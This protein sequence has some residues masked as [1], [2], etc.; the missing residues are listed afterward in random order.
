MGIDFNDLANKL[1]EEAAA[2]QT[3]IDAMIDRHGLIDQLAQHLLTLGGIDPADTT[4]VLVPAQAPKLPKTAAVDN[5]V[6][7]K[8]K[9]NYPAIAAWIIK[10]KA[11]GT[12]S[13]KAMAAAFNVHENK[14]ANWPGECRRRGLLDNVVALGPITKGS[15][16]QQAARD[17]A[18][19]P[20]M[21]K[22][23][24]LTSRA[25]SQIPAPT[26][27]PAGRGFSIDDATAVLA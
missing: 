6:G 7:R 9:H 14:V 22:V 1:R 19:G 25:P 3:E 10:H 5:T 17:A 24:G 12:Y 20:S 15:F 2:L 27:Q 4:P 21:G 11:A 26:V 18:A 8:T 13:L 23:R 16:D